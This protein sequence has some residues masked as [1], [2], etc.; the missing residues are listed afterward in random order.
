MS[1]CLFPQSVRAFNWIGK[2]LVLAAFL[3][4]FT[5]DTPAQD[6]P[7]TE[8]SETE[9]SEPIEAT[10][11]AGPA[12]REV[13]QVN[14]NSYSISG[15]SGL[16]DE[17]TEAISNEQYEVAI[18]RLLEARDIYNELSTFY[19]EL[20]GMFVGVDTRQNRNN[21]NKALETAQ[22]RDRVNYQLALLY[23]SQDQPEDAIPLLLAV[24][25]SQQPTRELGQQAYQQL[26]E[27]GFVDEPYDQ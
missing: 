8:E 14:D 3:S 2:A 20:A 23:R 4:L 16:E 11:D 17:A 9:L 19:Q 25:R 26:F 27:L 5:V 13:T 24:L 1:A 18:A 22:S 21:R 15:A 12:V 6:T 10:P 7:M